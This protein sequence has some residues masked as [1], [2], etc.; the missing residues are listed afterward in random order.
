LKYILTE[1]DCPWLTPVPYRGERNEPAYVKF[2]AEKIGEIKGIGF[3]EVAKVT[4]DNAK[5]LFGIYFFDY[6]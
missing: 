1:T 3:D 4:E 6:L 5:K 2:V